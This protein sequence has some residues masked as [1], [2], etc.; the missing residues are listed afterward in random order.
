MKHI[1]TGEL[2]T[3]NPKIYVITYVFHLTTGSI[4]RILFK[5][6]HQPFT[7]YE[8]TADE[9]IQKTTHIFSHQ[10]SNTNDLKTFYATKYKQDNEHPQGSSSKFNNDNFRIQKPGEVKEEKIKV[11]KSKNNR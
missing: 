7:P 8:M 2:F 5:L 4:T 9:F 3:I 6:Y 10:Q 1:Q 11:R